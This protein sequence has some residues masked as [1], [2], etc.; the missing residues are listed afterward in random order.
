MELDI[1]VI[2][3]VGSSYQLKTRK[4]DVQRTINLMPTRIESGSGKSQQYLQAIPGLGNGKKLVNGQA[5]TSAF[6]DAIPIP[7]PHICPAGPV[8]TPNTMP[9]MNYVSAAYGNGKFVA[10]GVTVGAAKNSSVSTDGITWRLSTGQ[11]PLVNQVSR[12]LFG[13]HIFFANDISGASFASSPDGDAWTPLGA[14]GG[15]V[16]TGGMAFGN[17]LFVVT[18]NGTNQVLS[19]V[20]FGSWTFHPLPVGFIG[21]AI[22]WTG[23]VWLV[24]ETGSAAPRVYSSPD[25]AAWTLVA[26]QASNTFGTNLMGYGGG[27]V[28]A[29]SGAGAA[30]IMYSTDHGLT[31]INTPLAHS[32]VVDSIN[33]QQGAFII[34]QSNNVSNSTNGIAWN[35]TASQIALSVPGSQWVFA[36]DGLTKYVA[37][38]A[39]SGGSTVHSVGLC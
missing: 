29:A 32:G 6:S 5:D 3:F 35:L 24:S 21:R 15:I 7:T 9:N 38:N 16:T 39:I 13:N 19:T 33:Y 1:H 23:S 17:G 14:L 10:G 31:W 25:L 26:P 2:P 36:S 8:W 37:V 27:V 34:L 18:D 22:V 12:I 28:V 20:G 4:A 11:V 30:F